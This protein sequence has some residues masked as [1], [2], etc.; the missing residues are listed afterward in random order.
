MQPFQQRVI[1]EKKELDEKL[2]RLGAFFDNETF[3][4][5]PEDERIR[6]KRQESLMQAYSEVLGERIAAFTV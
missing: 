4:G 5:L 3:N 2:Q 6:L 1:D